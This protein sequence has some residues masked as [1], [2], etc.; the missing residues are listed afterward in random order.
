MNKEETKDLMKILSVISLGTISLVFIIYYFGSYLGLIFN[1]LLFGFIIYHYLNLFL[2]NPI[3]KNIIQLRLKNYSWISFVIFLIFGF[4]TIFDKNSLSSDIFL[5][6]LYIASAVLILFKNTLKINKKGIILN[7]FMKTQIEY[8]EF[9]S[10]Q[11]TNDK[12][13][14]QSSSE[15]QTFHIQHLKDEEVNDILKRINKYKES[16]IAQHCI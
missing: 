2:R 11:V 15:N 9:K 6:I 4:I 14:I 12:I 10:I 5:G 16:T 8:S 3:R 7:D 1:I 13:I